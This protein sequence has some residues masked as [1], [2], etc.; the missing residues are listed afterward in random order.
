M[1]VFSPLIFTLNYG[2]LKTY[3]IF[4][5]ISLVKISQEKEAQGFK[6]IKKALVL[7]F[8]TYSCKIK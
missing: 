8:S 3:G 7:A 6:E 2:I 4:R 5:V 1:I